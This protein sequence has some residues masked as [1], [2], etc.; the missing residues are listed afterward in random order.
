MY[1]YIFHLLHSFYYA[2]YTNSIITLYIKGYL[3]NAIKAHNK[4]PSENLIKHKEY[5]FISNY[6]MAGTGF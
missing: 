2:L 6:L 4:S 3:I 5:Y 1:V